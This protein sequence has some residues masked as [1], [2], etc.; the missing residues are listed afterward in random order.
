V[1]SALNETADLLFEALN[2][3][4]TLKGRVMRVYSRTIERKM[5]KKKPPIPF[6]ENSLTVLSARGKEGLKKKAYE[7]ELFRTNPII[8]TTCGAASD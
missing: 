2:K 3:H 8:V 5:R 6:I 7:D 4:E 1:C